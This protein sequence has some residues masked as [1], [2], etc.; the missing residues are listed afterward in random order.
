MTLALFTA[1]KWNWYET[2]NL[3]F[4]T[5]RIWW[6][7]CSTYIC[8]ARRLLDPFLK[9]LRP[10]QNFPNGNSKRIFLNENCCILIEILLIFVHRGTLN[11]IPVLVQI[12]AWR[13]S[14]NNPLSEPIMAWLMTHICVT[15][16][17]L[18]IIYHKVK[19]ARK[20]TQD[21]TS[22][23]LKE[24]KVLRHYKYIHIWI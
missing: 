23:P 6:L 5:H 15:R 4:E 7:K 22:S 9:T 20:S 13:R 18:F 12:M 14:G 3:K 11:N 10:K 21:V 24:M 1:N 2:E 17:H 8:R 19:A 16:R